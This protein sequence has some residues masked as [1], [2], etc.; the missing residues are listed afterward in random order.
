MS[1]FINTALIVAGIDEE[2]Q[3]EV[4]DGIRSCIG[5]YNINISCF[6]AFGGVIANRKYDIGEYNIYNLINYDSFDSFILLT[7]TIND[8][9][10]RNS[11]IEKV[12]AQGKPAIV[13][14]NSD[15]PEFCNISIGNY[16]AMAEITEHQLQIRRHVT[17]WKRSGMSWLKTG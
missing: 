3:N 5:E 7:N 4:I 8:E 9:D 17:V 11:I 15:V 10:S 16:E 12:R 2:Y 13:L 6:A 14:D 1:D